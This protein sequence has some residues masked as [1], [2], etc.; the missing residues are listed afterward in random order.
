MPR[1]SWGTKTKVAKNKWRIRWCEWDGRDRVRK[2]KTLYPCTSR[3]A[4]D[5]LRR[6]W[7]LHH[8]RPEERDVPCPTFAQCWEDWFY[9]DLLR[10]VDS[11]EIA[12][13]TINNYLT[14]WR[15]RISKRWADVKLDSVRPQEYQ[16]WIN[17]IKPSLAPATHIAVA[18][19][20]K[21][22]K[23]H[24]VRGIDFMDVRYEMPKDRKK[25][26]DESAL[27][28]YTL[29][30][31]QRL[32]DEAHGMFFESVLILMA[33]GSCRVGEAVAAAVEDMSFETYNGHLY[34]VYDLHRQFA[35]RPN[36][37]GRLKTPDSYRPIIVPAPWS[38]RLREIAAERKADGELFLCDNGA[39]MPPWRSTIG[40]KWSDA[41]K[42]GDITLR[43]L[44]MSKLR[45][46]W[47]TAMLW[48]YD[49]PAQMVD[50]M[51][52]HAA[53]NVLGKNYDRPDKQMF[54]ETVDKALFGK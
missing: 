39:G 17:G 3:E 36:K 26:A 47:A 46:S 5:E 28:V 24:D 52:G 13:N 42:S 35:G 32:L 15:M 8:L 12:S 40:E 22:A 43:Y 54:I 45:N 4:D 51:M 29:D 9:P 10:K 53:K 48:K 38:E 33:K 31:M 21:C 25:R 23:L 18:K 7:Q 41:F 50:K 16:A 44:P 27:D 30:E 49:V 34:A 14:P 11:G 2:S 1:S 6:L 19:I 20:A 37:L